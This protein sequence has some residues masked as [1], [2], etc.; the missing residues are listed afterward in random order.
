MSNKVTQL[1]TSWL[2][3]K[4]RKESH[5]IRKVLSS[6]ESDEEDS[7]VKPTLVSPTSK[8]M[9]GKPNWDPF[10]TNVTRQIEVILTLTFYSSFCLVTFVV[11]GSQFGF[12]NINL[13]VGETN[14]GLTLLSSSSLSGED[15]T[16]LIWWDSFL[17]LDLSH[18]VF[19]CVTLFDI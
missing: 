6:P 14:V 3:S 8:L 4:I 9:F 13:D 1:K 2:R 5:Q 7:R 11:K 18:D 17:I 12:P 15:R 19:N 16:F 10:T